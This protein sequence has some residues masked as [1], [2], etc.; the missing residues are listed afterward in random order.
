MS[1]QQARL[2]RV[3]AV[4]VRVD[5]GLTDAGGREFAVAAAHSSFHA[6]GL[7]DIRRASRLTQQQVAEVLGTDQGTVSKIEHREDLLLSTLREYLTA[8]GAVRPKIV[9]EKDGVEIS[10]E[11]DVFGPSSAQGRGR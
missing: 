5:D 2:R 1:E 11:L 6:N 4:P 9:A 8:T 7:A 10:L 3:G